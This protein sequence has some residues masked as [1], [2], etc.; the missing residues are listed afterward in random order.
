RDVWLRGLRRRQH[1]VAARRLGDDLDVRLEREQRGERSPDDPLILGEEHADHRVTSPR[2]RRSARLGS[3]KGI[4]ARRPNPRAG[5]GPAANE[6]P[7]RATRSANPLKPLPVRPGRLPSLD[8][9]LPRPS[10]STSTTRAF[11][12]VVKRIVQCLARLCRT[13]LVTPSR[14]IQARTDSTAGGSGSSL[15]CSR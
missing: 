10:S 6:P 3:G 4:V 9:A 7:S 12:S 15:P 1:L 14:T 11:P 8:G 5:R 13:T 2:A